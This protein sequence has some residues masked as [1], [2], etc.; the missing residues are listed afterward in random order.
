VRTLVAGL[1]ALALLAACGGGSGSGQ[2]AGSTQITMTEF[3]FD[4]SNPSVKSGNVTFWLVNAG[5]TAHDMAIRDSS[6]KTLAT[7]E[8]VSAGDSTAFTVNSL[9]AGS[10]TIYCTQPGHEA[11][12][13][14]GTL[15]VT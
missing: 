1:A 10:Y 9:A 8:L 3:K 2:P 6:G 12:G 13:M 5:T 11:S 15:T 14:K 7:S 4:P